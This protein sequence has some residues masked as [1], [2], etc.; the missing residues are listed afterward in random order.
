MDVKGG[1]E[2]MSIKGI[3]AVVIIVLVLIAFAVLNPIV[4]VDAGKRAV[5][6]EWGLLLR[7]F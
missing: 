7:K 5:V 6:L 3:V 1:C 2:E 4:M